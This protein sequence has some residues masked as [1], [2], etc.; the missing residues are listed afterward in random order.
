MKKAI[1]GPS[2][3]EHIQV[4]VQIKNNFPPKF[5]DTTKIL[6]RHSSGSKRFIYKNTFFWSLYHAE[7]AFEWI[8]VRLMPQAYPA[9]SETGLGVSWVY[10]FPF[11]VGAPAC[12]ILP[13]ISNANDR[14]KSTEGILDTRCFGGLVQSCTCTSAST[15]SRYLW[16]G[17]GLCADT[18]TGPPSCTFTSK[19]KPGIGLLSSSVSKHSIRDLFRDGLHMYYL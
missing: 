10:Q 14:S 16:Q 18:A 11:S 8:A 6:Y 12:Y 19:S 17:L 3:S 15:G 5:R 13:L 1:S 7:D 4:D 2:S 9:V